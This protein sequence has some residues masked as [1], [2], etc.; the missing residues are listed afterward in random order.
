VIPEYRTGDL[1][2]TREQAIFWHEIL[3]NSPTH[4]LAPA[5]SVC[6]APEKELFYDPAN[7]A[8]ICK[9]CGCKSGT[10]LITHGHIVPR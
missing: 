4:R 1:A 2:Y 10:I 3:K 8:L 5:C 9:I 6:A 7:C